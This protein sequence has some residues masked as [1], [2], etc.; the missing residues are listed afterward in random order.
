[1]KVLF[2]CPYNPFPPNSGNKNLTYNLIKSLSNDINIDILIIEDDQEK[3]LSSKKSY[4]KKLVPLINN[5][6]SLRK[7]RVNFLFLVSLF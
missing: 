7:I 5:I 4:I 1:M 6:I 2:I 3:S